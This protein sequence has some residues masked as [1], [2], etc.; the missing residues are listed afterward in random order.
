MLHCSTVPQ[1]EKLDMNRKVIYDISSQARRIGI[2]CPDLQ[3]MDIMPFSFLIWKNGFEN[4]LE[5]EVIVGQ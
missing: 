5:S 1:R 4:F 2:H 3:W